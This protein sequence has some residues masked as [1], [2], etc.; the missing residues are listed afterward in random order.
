MNSNSKIKKGAIVSYISIIISIIA[1]IFY[2]PWMIREI[3]QNDYGLYSLA[4]SIITYLTMDFGLSF[5]VSRFLAKYNAENKQEE[6]INFL[7]LIYR[8]FIYISLLLSFILIILYFFINNIFINFTADEIEKFKT[9]YIILGFYSLLIF[10]FK[11]IDGILT[12][13]EYFFELKLFSFIQRILIIILMIISLLLGYHLYAL[14]TINAISGILITIFKFIF[15]NKKFKL[16]INLKYK[17]KELLNKIINF[18]FW[19]F[20]ISLIGNFS[21]SFSPSILGAVSGTIEISIFSIGSTFYGYSYSIAN[22]LSGLFLPKV[23]N[24]IYKNNDENR[25]QNLYIKVGRIQL[26]LLGFILI[27]FILIGKE[28]ITLWMKGLDFEKSFLVAILLIIPNLFIFSQSIGITALYSKNLVKYLAFSEVIKTIITITISFILSPE[29][30]A[31]G[32][33][34][35]L[36]IGNMFGKVV[37]LNIQYYKILK[38]NVYEFYRKTFIRFLIPFLFIFLISKGIIFFIPNNSYIYL[39]I[40]AIIISTIFI[41]ITW[42]YVFNDQEKSMFSSQIIKLISK[43]KNKI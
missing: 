32:A 36:F 34:I 35:G 28:F 38:L 41:F 17:N 26:L 2:T 33:A 14:V 27:G 40:K 31:I 16:K 11:P 15:V 18:S 21:E 8:L 9:I 3:G 7:G 29:L 4:L 10:P 24:I 39:L 23:T 22:A 13:Y 19:V 12:A 30:G 25:L 1:G 37:Y 5:S 42:F 20:V 6:I 43:Q